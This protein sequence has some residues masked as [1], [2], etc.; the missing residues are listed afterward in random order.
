MQRDTRT[1]FNQPNRS[2][3]AQANRTASGQSRVASPQVNRTTTNQAGGAGSHL[4]NPSATTAAMKNQPKDR[5]GQ[6]VVSLIFG[7]FGIIFFIVAMIK[8]NLIPSTATR[9]RQ[10]L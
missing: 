9:L 4:G 1:T 5:L 8:M 10:V 2:T 6:A 7:I 3:P